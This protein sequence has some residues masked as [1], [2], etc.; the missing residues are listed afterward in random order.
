MKIA[1]IGGGV[2]GASAAFEASVVDGHEVHI[3][4][5][6]DAVGRHQSGHNSGVVHAGLY[7]SPGSLKARLCRQGVVKLRSFAKEHG[8]AYKESGKLIVAQSASEV[9]QLE[10]I[11][12]SA[13]ANGVPGVDWLQDRDIADVEPNVS[14][15]AAL[16]SSQTAIVDYQGITRVLTAEVARRGGELRTGR[17]VDRVING[18]DSAQVH[19]MG[20]V[21]S[22]DRV[23]V[24]AGLQSDRIAEASGASKYPLIVPFYGSYY[25]LNDLDSRL[26]S[27]AIYPVPDPRYPFLGVH[28]TGSSQMRV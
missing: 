23:I 20:E 24:C 11:R 18:P 27:H 22:Y 28:I 17:S 1:V 21:E 3:Y 9:A 6:E 12:E 15:L 16:R 7:Y 2:I 5:K 13:Q 25:K 19:S 26:V 10:K 4:E 14:G 8:V